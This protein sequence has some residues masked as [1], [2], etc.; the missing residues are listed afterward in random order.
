MFLSYDRTYKQTEITTLYID[1]NILM[2]FKKHKFRILENQ[3]N[4]QLNLFL[5]I[6]SRRG[7]SR[8]NGVNLRK[9][10]FRIL[11]RTKITQDKS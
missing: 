10:R 3:A 11:M 4:I 8:D 7:I 6:F 1:T 5:R 9:L 2:I